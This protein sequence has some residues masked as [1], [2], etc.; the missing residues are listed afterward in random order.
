M[1]YDMR[2]GKEE[3]NYTYN[4]SG[5]FYAHNQQGIRLHYGMTGKEAIKPLRK[6]RKFM[7]NNME[8]LLKLNPENGWG[9]YY[10]ALEFVNKLI[11]ASIRN[12]NEIWQGD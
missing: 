1:S 10:G 7:E 6:L 9:D 11:L 8:D 4:V 5:M 12:P 3:F 2:I